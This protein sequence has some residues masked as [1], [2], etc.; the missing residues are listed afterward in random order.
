MVVIILKT[1]FRWYMHWCLACMCCI[2][3]IHVVMCHLASAHDVTVIN[4][5]SILLFVSNII[6][7]SI[8]RLLLLLRLFVRIH[9][10]SFGLGLL[11]IIHI[12]V[13]EV[14]LWWV[15]IMSCWWGLDLLIFHSIFI[16]ILFISWSTLLLFLSILLL[17]TI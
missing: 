3:H 8:G 6:L 14:G 13:V 2:R 9:N 11:N 7:C 4:D 10:Q 1:S 17:H 16:R 15:K 5:Y 12:Q